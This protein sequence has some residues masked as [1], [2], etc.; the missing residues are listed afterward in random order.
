LAKLKKP[1]PQVPLEAVHSVESLIDHL[2]GEGLKKP[3]I[4]Y[5]GRQLKYNEDLEYVEDDRITGEES[6]YIRI[7]GD[8]STRTEVALT[9]SHDC[10]GKAYMFGFRGTQRAPLIKLCEIV[11][12]AR[13]YTCIGY[14]HLAENPIIQ[15]GLS[16]GYKEAFKFTNK[17]SNNE[18]SEMYKILDD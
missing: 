9:E 16:M 4:Y 11:A 10:C 7:Q 15:I 1:Q 5:Q 18:L 14:L 6:Q 12:K 17:R 8:D 2:K 13:G 3:K